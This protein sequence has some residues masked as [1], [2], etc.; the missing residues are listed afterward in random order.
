MSFVDLKLLK[1]YNKKDPKE[2]LSLK[3]V[4][5]KGNSS[6]IQLKIPKMSEIILKKF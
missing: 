1:M 5:I 2:L 3:T 6:Q 4:D